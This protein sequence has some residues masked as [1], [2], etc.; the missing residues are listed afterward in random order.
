M[1]LCA[2]ACADAGRPLSIGELLTEMFALVTH[3]FDGG[4]DDDMDDVAP[5]PIER[6]VGGWVLCSPLLLQAVPAS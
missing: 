3:E 4:F 1:V 5:Q 6:Q 2:V